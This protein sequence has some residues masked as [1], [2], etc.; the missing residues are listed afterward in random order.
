MPCIKCGEIGS[1]FVAVE[2]GDDMNC[3]N[4]STDFTAADV[5]VFLDAWR[6]VLAWLKLHPSRGGENPGGLSSPQESK[7]GGV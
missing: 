4:C 6:P 1:V 5:E 2:T 7:G 3:G